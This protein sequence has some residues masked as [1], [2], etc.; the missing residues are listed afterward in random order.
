MEPLFKSLK[1]LPQKILGLPLPLRIVVFGGAAALIIA[2]G[3]MSNL[4][5][6]AESYQY[7]FTNLTA[8]DSSEASA[9]LKASGIPFRNEAGALAVPA[10]KVYDA[11]LLLAAA[12]LPRGGGVGFE[13]FDRGDLG[14]SEFTQR[15]NFR[16]ATEGDLARTIS[17]FSSVRSS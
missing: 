9:Q 17:H 3:L 7:A 1:E 5:S 11:R 13:L 10:S 14:V 2:I 16:R 8:E 15:V 12:G 6:S 4:A